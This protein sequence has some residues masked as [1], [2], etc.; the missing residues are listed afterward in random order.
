MSARNRR[1]KINFSVKRQMQMRLFFRVISI[2]A[3]G[4]GLMAVIFYLYSYREI[5][6]SYRQFHIQAQNF[7][8]YLLPAVILSLSAAIVLAAAI[9]VFFPHKI[10]GPLYRIEK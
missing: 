5:S 6:G 2:A 7:L 4:I 3:A 8:D 9:T 10:A 1:K